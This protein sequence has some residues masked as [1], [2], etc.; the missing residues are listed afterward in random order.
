M[1]GPDVGEVWFV[2]L[3]DSRGHEQSGSRPAVIMAVSYGM[4]IAVP[5]TTNHHASSFPHTHLMIPDEN[6]GLSEDSY[7][8][9]FQVVALDTNRFT[10]KWGYLSEDD[11][12][13]IKVLFQDMLQI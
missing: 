11:I 5:F 9:I 3:N 4:R 1:K 8:L 2:D 6:N 12:L 13:S 7:A 10:E